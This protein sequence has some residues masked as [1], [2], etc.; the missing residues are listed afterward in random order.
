MDVLLI[1]K[2]G[3]LALLANGIGLRIGFSDTR[4]RKLVHML[5]GGYM[6]V[7]DGG[8]SDLSQEFIDNNGPLFAY[9][10]EE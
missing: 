4:E 8:G 7:D 3:Q 10:V 6:V 1:T 2:A 5:D 9:V